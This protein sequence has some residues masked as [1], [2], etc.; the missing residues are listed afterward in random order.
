MLREMG[1]AVSE[2]ELLLLQD[3]GLSDA[4]RVIGLRIAALGEGF[5]EIVATEFSKMVYGYPNRETIA[6]HLRQLELAGYVERRPGGRG[7]ADAF[8]FRSVVSPPSKNIDPVKNEGL[9]DL[10]PRKTDVLKSL[11][12]GED[13][14]GIEPPI[15]PLRGSLSEKAEKLIG[16][17]PQL[18]GCRGSL[19]DYLA[20]RVPQSRQYAY[21]QTILGWLD[22]IHPGIWLLPTG[23]RLEKPERTR[24][25]AAALN[26]LAA[27]DESKLKRP[28][29]DVGNL[30]TKI[31][32]LIR[33][34]K[35]DR[36][37]DSRKNHTRATGTEG[38]A[39]Q[40]QSGRRRRNF[41]DDPD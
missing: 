15:S 32:V 5:H 28:V 41:T 6:R 31:N 1:N 24:M 37:S 30:Q 33:K 35:D 4:A 21:V 2:R 10:G 14:G 23:G 22:D 12:G 3:Q 8:S 25:L 20:A 7:H 29:G 36:S 38:R 27:S 19:R 26:D 17:R 9:N 18:T 13:E 40:D 16:E 34:R 39:H 11:V